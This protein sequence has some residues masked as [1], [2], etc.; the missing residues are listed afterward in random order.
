MQFRAIQ[1][2]LGLLLM[3][4]SITMLPPML[5]SLFYQDGFYISFLLGFALTLGTGLLIW[6]P[7]RNNR[8]ELRLR[9]GFVV[10]VMFWTVLGLFG[11]LPF[12]I[13]AEP[14]LSLADAVF[15]S[16]SGL[17]TTGATVITGLDTLPK[18]LLYY[19]QQLQWLGGM[20]I[21]VL[22]VA[23][24]P[25]LGIGGMQ[26][27]R[28]ETPGP[29]KENKL[30]PRITETAKA[31]WYIYLGLTAVC[32]LAYWLAGMTPFDAIGHSFSTV[33]IGGFSTHDA[34]M[35]YYVDQPLIE[36]IAI[37]F[38]LL[39]GTNFALHFLAL[40]RISTA[41]YQHDSEFRTYITVLA[42]VAGITVLYLHMT[43]TFS[44][45][46]SAALHGVFQV[47]S[48]G[49]TTGFTTSN[50]AAWPSFLPVMLLFVSFIGGCA[51]STGGG[52]KVIRFLLLLK[53][54][55]R[56]ISRLVHP[57]AVIPI[58]VGD[59]PMPER[60]VE[61]VWGFF[62][63]YVAIFAILL[64]ILMMT[65]LDQVT[66]FSAVAATM[67]N[68]G[69]GLGDVALHYADISSLAKWVLCFAMLLGRLEIFTLLVLL[70]PAFWRK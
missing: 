38:M 15:E 57:N 50:Y 5:V 39:A 32:A 68:L 70:T 52:M 46:G 35:G 3:L 4:F 44:D 49:T 48:I 7:A 42:T 56:E 11:A 26:L 37:V 28:A 19:R 1:R 33:A 54:G 40:R 65:G 30:T 23:I 29:M 24:L 41:P 6:L 64:L 27:Y 43:A 61:A 20:G 25:M 22:A 31:L 59:K 47:V 14:N 51:G 18:S 34:S 55:M 21:I 60:V 45:F 63:T 36:M 17:T 2:I 16:F 69:P 66:A 10:V 62:A 67:N 13:G 8:R 53:Q 12:M 9:D 58:K